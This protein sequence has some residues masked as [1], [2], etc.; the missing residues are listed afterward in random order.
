MIEELRLITFVLPSRNN[1]D[2]LKGA[3]ASIRALNQAHYVLILDDA[4]TDGT[5]KWIQELKDPRL[6]VFHNPGPQRIGIVGMFDKGISMAP[7]EIIFAFHADMVA[8]PGLDEAV[9]KLL[10]PKTVVCATRVEPPLHP[11]GPEKIVE[12]FGVEASEFEQGFLR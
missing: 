4:S 7:T 5:Q 11:K 10:K 1:L 3:Y 6:L 2:F 8:A 12:D 9:L